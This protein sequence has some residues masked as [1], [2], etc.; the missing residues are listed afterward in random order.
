MN[1]SST[2]AAAP[3]AAAAS[4]G[5]AKSAAT[6]SRLRNTG[7]NFGISR[8]Q[9]HFAQADLLHRSRHVGGENAATCGCSAEAIGNGADLNAIDL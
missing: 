3:S 1:V 4:T 9:F 2:P 5:A 8:H 6:S 7:N